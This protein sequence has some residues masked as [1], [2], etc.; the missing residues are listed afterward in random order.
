MTEGNVAVGG[1]RGPR[2]EPTMWLAMG[3]LA[4]LCFLPIEPTPTDLLFAAALGIGALSGRL[5]LRPEPWTLATLAFLALSSLPMLWSADY[6]ASFFYAGITIFLVAV[7]LLVAHLEEPE[8]LARW[9]RGAGLACAVTLLGLSAL[10]RLGVPTATVDSWY[11]RVAA[12]SVT[13]AESAVPG[14]YFAGRPKG[15]FKDPNIVG[16][17][18]ATIAT[19]YFARW[20]FDPRLARGV[21]APLL[22]ALCAL[23]TLASLSRGATINLVIGVGVVALLAV[24]QGRLPLKRLALFGG[25]VLGAA[26][27]TIALVASDEANQRFTQLNAYDLDRFGAWLDG[28]A[29]FARQPAGYGPGVFRFVSSDFG[30]RDPYAAHNLYVLLLVDNGVPGFVAFLVLVGVTVSGL[31]AGEPGRRAPTGLPLLTALDAGIVAALAGTLAESFLI[32]TLH[33]RHL[34]LL[35]GLGGALLLRRARRVGAPVPSF[36]PLSTALHGSR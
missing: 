6:R 17:F 16:A 36:F 1:A 33:W 25:I 19:L 35:L 7:T 24:W 20:L 27:F 14:L 29:S 5:R 18:L 9:F 28:L 30:H 31:L 3:A 4:L 10:S 8:R 34:W 32:D 21:R 13:G 26:A 23:G 15:F 11:A 12:F 22:A 2:I